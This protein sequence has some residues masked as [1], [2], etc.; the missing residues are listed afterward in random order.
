MNLT[1]KAYEILPKESEKIRIDVFVTEQGFD[2]EFDD[3]DH[4]AIH[5]VAYDDDKAVGTC[6][7]FPSEEG[8]TF[9]LGRI[10]VVFEYR[11]KGLGRYL[12]NQAETVA[13]E[14]GARRIKLHSQCRV[15]NF[16]ERCG[17]ITIGDID[18][19]Q[20][21]PHIWMVKDLNE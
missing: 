14:R 9:F 6:R 13:S 21:C 20:D 4:S 16:Y 17:Y 12:I 3:I 19:E 7:I 1:A 2:E 5:I 10:A 11:G 8:G 15:I 18:Y